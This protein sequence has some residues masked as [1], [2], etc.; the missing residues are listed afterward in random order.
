MF[1]YVFLIYANIKWINKLKYFSF[2]RFP[3]ANNTSCGRRSDRTNPLIKG[4][5]NDK[6]LVKNSI[7][8]I[9]TPSLINTKWLIIHLL[10][11]KSCWTNPLFLKYILQKAKDKLIFPQRV[12]FSKIVLYILF[13]ILILNATWI[14]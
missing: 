1:L 13:V 6:N 3:H 12:W 7:I 5:F 9:S 10:L 2:K 4:L 11:L 8:F 14:L